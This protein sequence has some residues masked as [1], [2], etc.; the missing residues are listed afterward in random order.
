MILIAGHHFFS[1]AVPL[2]PG[3][4]AQDVPAQAALLLEGGAPFPADQ[5][6]AGHFHVTAGD[7]GLVVFAAMRRK[8]AAEQEAWKNAAFVVPDFATWLPCAPTHAAVVLLDTP[9]GVTALDFPGATALPRQIVSRPRPP[10]TEDG[11]GGADLHEAML[12]RIDAEG[13]PVMRYRLGDVP[14]LQEGGRY[15]FDWQPVDGSPPLSAPAAFTAAQMWAMNLRDPE[16][17]K[18]KRRDYQWNR[19]AWNVLLASGAAAALLLIGEILLFGGGLM[20]RQRQ[21]RIEAQAPAA[22]KAQTSSDLVD[23]LSGYLDRKPRPLEMLA[24]LNEQRP[25]SIYF[26]KVS[27]DGATQVLIEASTPTPADVNEYEA[28]LKSSPL[29]ASVEVRNNRVRDGGGTFQLAVTFRPGFKL[30]PTAASPPQTAPSGAPP[31]AR[32]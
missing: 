6:A 29:L 32:S 14:C 24:F 22:Q 7:G 20:L 2:A 5:M 12:A 10:E 11:Q 26:T 3:T 16:F 15:L 21:A 8:F 4:G 17:L 25:H 18:V 27:I 19:L 13:R 30:A 23:R 28:A 1:D 9:Q 31:P